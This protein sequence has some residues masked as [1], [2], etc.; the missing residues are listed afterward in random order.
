MITVKRVVALLAL[1]GLTACSGMETASRNATGLSA[2]TVPGPALSVSPEALAPV[3]LVGYEVE[4]PQ[5]LKVSE[6]NAYIPRGDIVWRGEPQGDRYA[7]VKA[8]FDDS[9][10]ASA[11]GLTT[12]VPV[13]VK[14]VVRRFHALTEK[15]RYTTGGVH[16]IVFDVAIFHAVTGELLRPIKTVRA[17]LKA[18]G[19]SAAIAADA[20]GQ[21]QRV[22]ITSHLSNTFL[23]E[24]T[25]PA[26]HQN[27]QLGLIQA[28]NY[29]R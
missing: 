3:T 18:F 2:G 10:R 19:G 23:Q 9:L 27:A 24:L 11:A 5:S 29:A 21:T 1:F 25:A 7:Q 26:G 8:I 16:N 13:N 6:A 20:A 22:R 4:V 14:I 15:A 12:G 28:M 17:D